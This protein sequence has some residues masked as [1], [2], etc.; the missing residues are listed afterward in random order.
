MDTY[1]TRREVERRTRPAR[2]TLRA[3]G[4][5]RFD[6]PPPLV[7]THDC[8]WC[9]RHPERSHPV[10]AAAQDRYRRATYLR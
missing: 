9:D 5:D 10:D 7:C 8:D 1:M 3:T 6:D 2:T 4:V